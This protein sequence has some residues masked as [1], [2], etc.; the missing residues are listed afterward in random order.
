MDLRRGLPRTKEYIDATEKIGTSSDNVKIFKSFISI[1][2]AE[3][4]KNAVDLI[5]PD[6]PD[7][8][9][10]ERRQTAVKDLPQEEQE[11]V[12]KYIE[13]AF[14]KINSEYDVSLEH[15]LDDHWIV[16]WS[17]GNFMAMH[18][19]DDVVSN[20]QVSAVMY[21]GNDYEG[22][23]IVF[24]KQKLKVKPVAGDLIIFPGNKNYPHGVSKIKSGHR[25]SLPLWGK[26]KQLNNTEFSTD[27]IW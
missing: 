23:E 9:P 7:V 17:E 6:G 4:I 16:K 25:Y 22:G 20:F 18:A 24:P 21:F 15:S 1:E 14:K 27:E 19:D 10:E 13:L 5:L 11:L 12:N 8:D 3:T 26:Y 2:D